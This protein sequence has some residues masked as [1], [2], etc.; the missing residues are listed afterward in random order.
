MNS[1]KSALRLLSFT[2][3]L[4][5][6]L[7]GCIGF[8]HKSINETDS[9]QKSLSEI[10]AETVETYALTEEEQTTVRNGNDFSF[11]LF[12]KIAESKKDENIFVSTIG[13]FYSLNI[14]NNGASG[15]TQQEICNALNMAP[16]DIERANNLCR[17]FIVG[18]AKIV[19]DDFLG[20]S[21]YMRTATLFQAGEKV[22]I[23][24]SFQDVL[25]QN[26]FA[27]IIKG[28]IDGAK[29]QRI[30]KWCSAHTEGL[31]NELKIKE[32]DDDSAT[33]LV[34]NYFNGRWV[35]KF[36]KKDTK[37]E[38]FYG[39]TSSRVNMMNQT[40][41]EGTFTYAKLKNYSM[42]EIPYVGGYELY[43]ILPDK[44]D[45]LTA[46][47]QSLDESKIRH[48]MS[49]LKSYDRVY[50]KIPKFKVDYTFKANEFLA[51]LGISKMFSNN[52]EL[53]HIQSSPM[54]I[55]EILQSTKVI[56]DEDGTRAGALTSASFATLGL[57]SHPTEAYFYADHPFAY[58]ITD[59]FGNYCFM[60]TFRG[61]SLS[62]RGVRGV[63]F[64]DNEADVLM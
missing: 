17:R 8:S 4:L 61:P 7:V 25:E 6:F 45:G 27:G 64:D 53:T 60:G 44:V 11:K 5:I 38:P 24:K 52:Y 56:L 13:M 47:L 28:K 58:I 46:L 33:L 36:D 9:Q 29:Q 2:M 40:E 26:Y 18:Q 16:I 31:L 62:I 10:A 48:A 59:P 14:I 39:G 54:K 41:C 49:C 1:I 50:T 21:S 55:T 23:D 35:Q 43:I 34:A 37:D 32:V 57:I 51:S 63:N 3:C 20:P 22:D 15:E 12:K 19:E 30:N 42:L